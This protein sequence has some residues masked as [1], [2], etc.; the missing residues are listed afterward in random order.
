M[1]KTNIGQTS[2]RA[3]EVSPRLASQIEQ[4]GR[5]KGLGLVSNW[6]VTLQGSLITTM[7]AEFI[8]SVGGA[9]CRLFS[10][11]VTPYYSTVVIATE[12]K[13][14]FFNT[15]GYLPEGLI[16]AEYFRQGFRY[17]TEVVA[18]SGYLEAGFGLATMYN[19]FSDEGG[20]GIKF[21]SASP[22]STEDYDTVLR[23]YIHSVRGYG[24]IA[25]GYDG[26]STIIASTYFRD[27]GAV[28]VDA[29]IPSGTTGHTILIEALGDDSEIK[30]S[31]IQQYLTSGDYA[32]EV[33]T[34]WTTSDLATMQAIRTSQ[35]GTPVLYVASASSEPVLLAYY[36]RRLAYSPVGLPPFAEGEWPMSIL[37]YGGRLWLGGAYNYKATFWGSKTNDFDDFTVGALADDGIEALIDD[38]G[39]TIAWMEGVQGRGMLIGT[40]NA[41]HTI[42]ASAGVLAPGDVNTAMQSSHGSV[43]GGVIRVGEQPVFLDRS[44][45]RL[46]ATE[47]DW[48]SDVWKSQDVSFS[49]EHLLKGRRSLVRMAYASNPRNQIVGLTQD[50]EVVKNVYDPLTKASGW[51]RRSTNGRIVDIVVLSS[52]DADELWWVVDRGDEEPGFRLERIREDEN[53]KLDSHLRYTAPVTASGEYVEVTSFEVPHL[54]GQTCQ[55]LVDGNLHPDVLVDALGVATLE[56][57]GGEIKIGLPISNVVKTLPVS[58]KGD[59]RGITAFL[60]KRFTEIWAQILN[61]W[62]P[63]INGHRLPNRHTATPMG[64]SEP[65][66]TQLV[67]YADEGWSNEATI[68]VEQDLPLPTEIAGLYG[69]IIQEDI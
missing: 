19:R 38:D 12:G 60:N 11:E 22:P 67:R 37:V 30:V 36:G 18:P 20:T 5:D 48:Q 45:S 16:F 66:V 59:Q 15:L 64:E 4:D 46:R 65:A 10:I 53:V 13:A 7:G 39:G 14:T 49:G 1:P 52:G 2:F 33:S 69:K 44:R 24:R 43:L 62:L 34:D 31:H 61:S 27:K 58:E 47:Y 29:L 21:V 28:R 17:W 51:S 9:P 68:T 23:A 57:A 8:A 41:E 3:G 40:T 63:K 26:G 55:V 25:V 35:S 6:D 56:W 32:R 54:A 50:G 42:H